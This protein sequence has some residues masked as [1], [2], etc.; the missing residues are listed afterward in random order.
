MKVSGGREERT[1]GIGVPM[2]GKESGAKLRGSGRSPELR[3]GR[4]GME[5]SGT[6]VPFPG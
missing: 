6:G 1:A 2:G 3:G 5:T 4:K